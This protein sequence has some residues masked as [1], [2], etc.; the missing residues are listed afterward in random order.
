MNREIADKITSEIIDKLQKGT[1]P[2]SRPWGTGETPQSLTTQKEYRG[3]NRW[4]LWA[5]GYTSPFWTTY[6]TA[7]KLG[8]H[9]R[10]G[11]K[12]T[13]ILYWN[14]RY[15]RDGK[16]VKNYDSLNDT[17]RA[18]CVAVPF[19]KIAYVFN[20]EQCEGLPIPEREVR[21][22]ELIAESEKLITEYFGREN[23]PTLQ[24]ANIG[25][26]YYS[27]IYDI[28]NVPPQGNFASDP[29]Y[30]S[31]LFHEM[32]HS[33]GHPSRL[34]RLTP[35]HFADEPYSKE[36]LIAELGAC[37]LCAL[38]GIAERT[39][40]NSASYIDSWI[41][42]LKGDSTLVISAASQ[43]EKAVDYIKGEQE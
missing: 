7:Q 5:A 29:E 32:V 3:I 6:R 11:E 22:V 16:T 21:H 8:G 14:V 4:I 28:V 37:M 41:Q 30:Y 39:I 18:E 2:W 35:A 42:A 38:V 40:D 43:S 25:R 13:P 10:K 34:A 9:V 19:S 24:H 15:M 27:P 33:T 36:E 17:E 23:A 1:I 12:G 20:V 26:S 31:T